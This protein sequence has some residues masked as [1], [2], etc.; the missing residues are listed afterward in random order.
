MF[1]FYPSPMAWMGWQRFWV[2]GLGMTHTKVWLYENCC[3]ALYV[4]AY[5]YADV[6]V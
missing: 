2:L 4:Y 1:L 3:T 6:D 5:A